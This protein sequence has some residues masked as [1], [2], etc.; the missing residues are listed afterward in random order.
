MPTHESARLAY[1]DYAAMPSDGK[2]REILDGAL[3]VTPAPSPQ[4][5]R[6]VLRLATHLRGRLGPGVEVFIAPL[7]VILSPHDVLQPDVLAV[8]DAA[9]VSARGIEGAPLLV[10]EVLSPT[11]RAYDRTEKAAGYARLG[12]PH[13][14]LVDSQ[15]YR[16]E[17]L[18]RTARG[19]RTVAVGGRDGVLTHPDFPRL[20]LSLPRLWR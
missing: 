5:Q 7:D 13:L 12:V 8:A 16:L 9:Q 20:K 15:G 4:H 11:T 10:V 17:C 14:W 2:R 3:H 19:Y 6:L 1:E 18:R